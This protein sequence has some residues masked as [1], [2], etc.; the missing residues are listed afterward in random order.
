MIDDYERRDIAMKNVKD[1]LIAVLVITLL[2][3]A[4]IEW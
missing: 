1:I 4:G 2:L 3:L